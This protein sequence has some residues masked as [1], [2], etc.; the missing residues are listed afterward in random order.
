MTNAC[1]KFCDAGGRVSTYRVGPR[2]RKFNTGKGEK[3]SMGGWVAVLGCSLMTLPLRFQILQPNPVYSTC[4]I[5][6]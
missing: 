3:L 2:S 1:R 6:S 5:I 4:C